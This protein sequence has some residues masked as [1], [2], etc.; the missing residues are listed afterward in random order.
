VFNKCGTR[1]NV[2]NFTLTSLGVV[3][4]I[5]LF[6]MLWVMYTYVGQCKCDDM[7]KFLMFALRKSQ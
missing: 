7:M 3:W 6:F 4:S 5:Y 2:F 1:I